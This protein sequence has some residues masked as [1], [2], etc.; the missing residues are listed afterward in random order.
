MPAHAH[1]ISQTDLHALR[2]LPLWE[3]LRPHTP[4]GEQLKRQSRPYRAE[5]RALWQTH[6]DDVVQLTPFV[7]DHDR[8]AL[9]VK[10]MPDITPML[11][12]WQDGTPLTRVDWFAI[13]Q[14]LH[15]G[16]RVLA[17]RRWEELWGWFPFDTHER[18]Q[19]LLSILS[20]H[21]RKGEDDGAHFHFE[22]LFPDLFA[23]LLTEL[24]AIEVEQAK[25]E[26]AR[27]E[28]LEKELGFALGRN[29]PFY[30][31]R[32]D[33]D[34]LAQL[35]AHPALVVVRETPFDV[36]FTW[37]NDDVHHDL[38]TRR[39]KHDVRWHVAEQ[40]AHA[41]LAEQ[42][43]PYR[44]ELLIWVETFARLDFAYAKACLGARY[45][46]VVADWDEDTGR[47]TLSAGVHPWLAEQWQTHDR[48][49]TP[50]DIEIARGEVAVIIGP[51]MGGKSV[52]LKT[53]GLC[54]WLAQMGL[55][56]PAKYF[57][58]VPQEGI[59]YIGGEQENVEVGLS[60]FGGEVQQLV[61]LFQ[62]PSTER[63][64]VLCDE[65]G[66]GTNPEEGEALAVAIVEALGQTSW[67]TCFV[68]HYSSV[69][70]L[71]NLALY[72]IR[73]WDAQTDD[74]ASHSPMQE[75]TTT[76]G[77]RDEALRIVIDHRLERVYT[78]EVPHTALKLASIMGLP[79][80]IVTRAQNALE[81]KKK[82]EVTRE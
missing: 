9:Y 55:L 51:N 21:I 11:R 65:V 10:G 75:G 14:F 16:A 24:Q 13:Q 26:H 20:P 73:G 34:R 4:M 80:A 22:G 1:F 72:Q 45:D 47:V 63:L 68:S 56:V 50:V 82:G 43:F 48:T 41:R 81:H 18:W 78:G 59:V 61:D 28:R 71:P 2:A 27:K 76:A 60:S 25:H 8:Y 70:G 38:R 29:D 5:D 58:F 74:T 36:A 79:Q 6:M 15:K 62:R 31:S 23:T 32:K 12:A 52:A 66:R 19:S 37:A 39:E 69:V 57:R 44:E 40:E 77:T 42:I 64:L 17:Q 35:L 54:T 46:G 7:N 3:Q 53:L 49:F 33:D 30:I 67:Y